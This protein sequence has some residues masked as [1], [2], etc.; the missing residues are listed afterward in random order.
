VSVKPH[1]SWLGVTSPPSVIMSAGVS[2]GPGQG[3]QLIASHAYSVTTV[4]G[5]RETVSRKTDS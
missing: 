1:A 2:V 4:R 3:S 5:L